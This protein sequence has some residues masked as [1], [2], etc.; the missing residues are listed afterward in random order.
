MSYAGFIL[1]HAPDLLPQVRDK[2]I[3]LDDAYKQAKQ[4][5]KD[6]GRTRIT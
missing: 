2:K 3:A 1:D 5:E 4:R 6:A